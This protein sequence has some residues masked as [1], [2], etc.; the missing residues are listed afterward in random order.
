MSSTDNPGNGAQQDSSPVAENAE[1][2]SPEAVSQ[3]PL[4]PPYAETPAEAGASAAVTPEAGTLE[5]PVPGDAAV[6]DPTT[7][8]PVPTAPKPRPMAPRPAPQPS[9]AP[10]A[11][12]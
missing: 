6:A 5:A 3:Q 9:P 7:D 8:A 10:A 12:A 1:T 2:V 11:P 4:E